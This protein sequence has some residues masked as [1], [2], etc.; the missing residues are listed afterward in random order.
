M[1]S[2]K[3]M[4]PAFVG[5]FFLFS[6]NLAHAFD[7]LE[8]A[9]R[10]I[11]IC[12][13]PTANPEDAESFFIEEPVADGKMER[14]KVKVGYKG[15]FFSN[16]MTMNIWVREDKKVRIEILDDTNRTGTRD[17]KYEKGFHH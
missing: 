14:A 7:F 16:E 8:F 5:F 6:S 10:S 11:L 3:I 1:K 13:H 9:A 12:A 15:W 4:I 2:N 17:C